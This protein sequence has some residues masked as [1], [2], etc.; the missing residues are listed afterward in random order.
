MAASILADGPCS[1]GDV[2]RLRDANIYLGG[3][4]GSSVLGTGN[5]MMAAVMA[6]GQTIIEHAACEPEVVDLA[7]FLVAMGASIEGAGSHRIRIRGVR[8]LEGC[9]YDVIP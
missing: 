8:R 1:I 7:N 9:S 5:V 2:P 3:P 4:S 6:E